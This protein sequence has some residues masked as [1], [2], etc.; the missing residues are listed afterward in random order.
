MARKSGKTK[1]VVVVTVQ[2]GCAEEALNTG[3]SVVVL[4]WDGMQAASSDQVLGSIATVGKQVPDGAARERLLSELREC[5]ESAKARE[6]LSE[7]A[8]S[9]SGNAGKSGGP[10]RHDGKGLTRCVLCR[11]Q[12]KKSAIH[13]DRDGEPVCDDCFDERMR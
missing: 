8:M 7:H 5:L 10:K 3:A 13:L 2:G 4:D 12:V 11:R 1:P 6:R 9:D